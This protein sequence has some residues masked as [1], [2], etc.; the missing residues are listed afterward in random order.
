MALVL[1]HPTAATLRCSGNINIYQTT[2]FKEIPRSISINLGK[3]L[4][5]SPTRRSRKWPRSNA[6]PL[7][8][9]RSISLVPRLTDRSLRISIRNGILV[10]PA[11]F[12]CQRTESVKT[13]TIFNQDT[14]RES[15][16]N[17]LSVSNMKRSF[18]P[19]LLLA[20][21][22]LAS[23][24]AP[25]DSSDSVMRPGPSSNGHGG[26]GSVAD[27]HPAW[28]FMATAATQYHGTN[29]TRTTIRV[30]DSDGTDYA[31]IYTATNSTSVEQVRYPTWSPN[32][33]SISFVDG[34]PPT[35]TWYANATN[36]GNYSIKTVDVSV[37]NGVASGSNVR[38]VCS[39]T[40]SDQIV[41]VEQRWCPAPSVD[42]IAFI[43]VTPAGWG[44]YTVA[45]SGATPTRIYL[46]PS[47]ARINPGPLEGNALG[48]S[49][50]G[51][52]IA[53]AQRDSASDGTL[54]YSIKIINVSDGSVATTLDDGSDHVLG[55]VQWSHSGA[56]NQN[57]LS[58]YRTTVMTNPATSDWNLYTISTSG[59]TPSLVSTA[60]MMGFWSPNNSELVYTAYTTSGAVI[61][62]I[63]VA[64]GST[65]ALSISTGY[66]ANY[67]DWKQP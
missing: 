66:V 6:R 14:V 1:T 30:S 53:F 15:A 2:G 57:Q 27:A 11:I 19:L 48:W 16:G 65:T 24:E 29:T 50:D 21:A 8:F 32:G 40:S 43:G 3:R 51:S 49:N 41:I 52:R 36:Y 10:V 61:K 67:G 34:V 46:A 60:A 38:T 12:V 25:S 56:F 26:G 44:I 58:Y 13:W 7:S 4:T 20:S 47:N 62:K 54:S 63:D 59:S 28:T 45:A 23:C 39:Y 33:S 42:K 9:F 31:D 18:L 37:A 55:G 5:L 22:W 17:F 64:S 35:S